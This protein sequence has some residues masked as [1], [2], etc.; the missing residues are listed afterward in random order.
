MRVPESPFD[1]TITPR[2]RDNC[3]RGAEGR[4][5]VVWLMSGVDVRQLFMGGWRG[6]VQVFRK[7][8]AL[9]F[10]SVMVRDGGFFAPR[11]R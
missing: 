7:F 5:G 3:G 8:C 1:T 10:E 2:E 6:G 4:L 9:Q 11:E